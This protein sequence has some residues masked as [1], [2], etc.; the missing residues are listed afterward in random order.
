MLEL[1]ALRDESQGAGMQQ[2]DSKA[3]VE[4]ATNQ[5]IHRLEND[6]LTR[7]YPGWA[8]EVKTDEFKKWSLEGGPTSTEFAKLQ[9]T[10]QYDQNQ[11]Q[12]IVTAWQ[13]LYPDWWLNK[14]STMFSDRHSDIQIVLDSYS[15]SKSEPVANTASAKAN[16]KA[17]NTKRL[18][19]ALSPEGSP[20]APTPG[21]TDNEA[22]SRG[23][24][25]A[26][27]R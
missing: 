15:E 9:V 21:I 4:E 13:G 23:F 25:K 2:I 22:F 7:A 10:S 18:A 14:G 1:Q 11:A 27:G 6:A 17:R 8:E 3:L 20:E 24:K 26:S 12:Q 19:A 5:A 16:K